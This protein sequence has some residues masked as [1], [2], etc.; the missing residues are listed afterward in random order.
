[1]R[2]LAAL[3]NLSQTY[4]TTPAALALAW[5]IAQPGIT[6]AIT[7]ATSVEQLEELKNATENEIGWRVNRNLDEGER[8]TI[9][10]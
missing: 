9:D 4:Q 7:S 1:M 5:L 3:D 8:I 6:G 2:I 10:E